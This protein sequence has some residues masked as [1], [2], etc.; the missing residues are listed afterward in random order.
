MV[1]S[2]RAALDKTDTISEIILTLGINSNVVCVVVEGDD[3]E[4]VYAPLLSPNV[5]LFQSYS[6]KTGVE[7][8]IRHF[9][10]NQRVIGIRDRDYIRRSPLKKL[11]LTDFC[12]LEI[13]IVSVQGC[14]DRLYS[15]Y[16]RGKMTIEELRFHCLSC[17]ERFSKLRRLNEQINLNID[18][19]GIN[20]NRSFDPDYGKMDSNLFCEVKRQNP[21]VNPSLYMFLLEDKHCMNCDDLLY[22]VNGH[23]FISIF[24]SICHQFS[25]KPSLAK[26]EASLFSCFGHAEF[27]CT[28]LY[29]SLL[30]YQNKHRVKI[31]TVNT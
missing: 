30:N 14:F 22:I 13:M 7:D 25:G 31:L 3:D 17:L 2:I 6:G 28:D 1:N 12:C 9:K 23:D 4:N 15:Q 16:Y 27:R 29:N 18:F 5:Y 26:I 21:S 20:I 8:V 10:Y 19:K 11:F 24:Y